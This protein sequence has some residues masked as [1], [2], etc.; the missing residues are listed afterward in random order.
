VDPEY[1]PS[2]EFL[3]DS[4]PSFR[5]TALDSDNVFE[6]HR[7][8][9]VV[10]D[11]RSTFVVPLPRRF[12]EPRDFFNNH[13]F[14]DARPSFDDGII[15]N[16]VFQDERPSFQFAF[17]GNV[18]DERPSFNISEP[19]AH[20][21]RLS[22]DLSIPAQ[23]E[24]RSFGDVVDGNPLIDYGRTIGHGFDDVAFRRQHRRSLHTVP[25]AQYVPI[26]FGDGVSRH[27]DF[28]AESTTAPAGADEVQ[29]NT[30]VSSGSTPHGDDD[31]LQ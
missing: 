26:Q 29:L 17:P 24:R 1:R 6:E 8:T 18:T 10:E 16:N 30:E 20:D 4:R 12:Q 25:G 22:F 3:E 31:V 28:D 19:P 23:D 21:T 15:D 7:P 9:F 5:V 11:Q 14:E 2:F 13:A 27:P